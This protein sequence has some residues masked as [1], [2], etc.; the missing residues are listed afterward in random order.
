[1]SQPV[2][3]LSGGQRQALTL[4]MATFNPPKLLL[5]DE[6]TEGIQPSVIQEIGDAI[7]TI[8]RET[9]LS[10]LLVERRSTPQRLKKFSRS[11]RALSAK[12]TSPAL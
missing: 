2:G 7:R 9:G 4:M 1:M 5:L 10:I 6:P 3:L 11:Q 12:I 8:N